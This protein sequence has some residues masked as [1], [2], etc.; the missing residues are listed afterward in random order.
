M[1]VRFILTALFTVSLIVNFD[2][3]A[4]AASASD[5]FLDHASNYFEQ[6]HYLLAL[7]ETDRA[8]QNAA[9]RNQQ[10]KAY[11]MKGNILL[12]ML[13]YNEAEQSLLQAFNLAEETQSKANYANDLGVLYH[14]IRD[15][16][17]SVQY[18]NSAL[19]LVNNDSPLALKIKLNKLRAQPETAKLAQL[20][21][22]LAEVFMIQP[23]RE[24]VRYAL[25]LASIASH[26]QSAQPVTQAALEKAHMDSAH[27]NDEQL[28]LETLD[29]LSEFYEKQG[30]YQQ[31]L[32]LS[33]QAS[34]MSTQLDADD[35]LINIEWR[36]GR[37]YQRFGR[38]E[39]ALTA[40]RKAVDHIQMIRRDIPVTYEDGKSSFREKLEPIYLG[41]AHHLLK[42]S[43]Q[44][45]DHTKQQTLRLARQTIE[46][47][48]QSE[49]EDFLGGRCLV[50][51]LQ[52][53]ALE[54][55]DTDAAI[56]YP[57]ILPDRL[58]LLVSIGKTIHQ[59]TVNVPEQ[60]VRNAALNL[61]DYLRNWILLPEFANEMDGYR[62]N[63][64]KLYRWIITP[65]ER[66]L[67]IKSIKTL[68]VVPDGVLRLVPFS[69]LYDGKQF[70]IEKYAVS[71]SPGISL[72]SSDKKITS[73]SYQSLLAGLSKPGSVV[74]KLPESI[75]GGILQ[76]APSEVKQRKSP[77]ARG[78][79]SHYVRTIENKSDLP[80]AQETNN[81][82]MILKLQEELS[83][84]GVETELSS[85]KDTLKSKTLLNEQFTV[86]NFYQQVASQPYEIIHIAS[87]G[88]FSTDANSSFLMAYDDVIKL[89]ELK[90]FLKQDRN[91]KGS[92]Q[93]LTLSACETAEGDDRAP[94]GFTG[95]ALKAD[96]QSALGSLW[97]I[98]D[99]AASRLMIHFYKN[100]T[101]HRSKTES[102]RQ[103]QLE[104]LNST[105]M[106]HP[107]FWSPF[108][109]VGNWL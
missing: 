82:S 41:Y 11:G 43:A 94:L 95:V 79:L 67:A 47:I 31:A 4:L 8:L 19:A 5:N 98:S 39:E 46:Q 101:Q 76:D 91:S 14:E 18:F 25:N 30:K 56:L 55:L 42:K 33:E 57:I 45:H 62:Q 68:V 59:L 102:L 70:L 17:R 51:G 107:S 10:S 104:L 12:L 37:I 2:K 109:L 106:N 81:R 58:E 86:K 29:S 24:R 108:I 38:D 92:I 105:D 44:Q 13:R 80:I 9:S 87:H 75:I 20:E 1:I 32:D 88:L 34:A 69:A 84:P 72:M 74:D 6:G 83:L 90:T 99:D 22:L 48:K 26:H 16:N 7:Q 71:I 27:V 54:N 65:I 60:E 63:S 61:S 77:I 64:E 85:L 36:K 97:P 50:Q 89:D 23:L 78:I 93:L 3:I 15:K 73:R 53:N 21:Q 100:L 52:R 49:L 103:A 96:A 35:L 28:Q 40:F 66:K